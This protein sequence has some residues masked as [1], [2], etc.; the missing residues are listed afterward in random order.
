M[1]PGASF[2]GQSTPFVFTA[3]VY[4]LIAFPSQP[5][6]RESDLANSALLR[7]AVDWTVSAAIH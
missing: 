2:G 5:E 1:K 6:E 4:R 7:N 3:F